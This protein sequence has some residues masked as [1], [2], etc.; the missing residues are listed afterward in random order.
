MEIIGTISEI[1]STKG[2]QVW[3]TSP[4]AMVF[5]ALKL[6]GEKNVGALLVMEGSKLAGVISERDYSRK[7]VLRGKNSRTTPV[8]DILSTPVI[9]VTPQHTVQDC[10]QL[11]T[12]HR[13]RHLPVLQEGEVVGIVSIGDLVNWIIN[14]QR[15]AIDQLKNYIAGQYPG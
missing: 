8:H 10:M 6:M 9:S 15:Q 5:D 12:N 1:L 14:A 3:N 13:I 2:S 4:D 7:V 11:M